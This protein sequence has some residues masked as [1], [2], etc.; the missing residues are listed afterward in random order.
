[1]AYMVRSTDGWSPLMPMALPCSRSVGRNTRAL[2]LVSAYAAEMGLTLRQRP[3]EA[4]SNEIEAIKDLLPALAWRRGGDDWCD[5][6]SDQ[7]ASWIVDGS[8]NHMLAVKDNRAALTTALRGSSPA[9]INPVIRRGMRST[10]AT[11]GS[12]PA[13]A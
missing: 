4:N 12:R 1:M 10:K 6:L 2:H 3:C 11:A 7:N 8:G 13:A 9:W 5:R